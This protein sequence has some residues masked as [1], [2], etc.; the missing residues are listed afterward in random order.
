MITIYPAETNNGV[1]TSWIPLTTVYTPPASCYDVYKDSQGML[2]AFDPNYGLDVDSNVQC[3]PLAETTWWAQT[4]LGW[5]GKGHT[6]ASLGPMTCPHQWTTV[7][8]SVK[9]IYS[10]A[11]MCCPS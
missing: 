10:T 9:D 5:W 8:T 4:R 1:A 7:A 3:A 11:A 2:M 6:D